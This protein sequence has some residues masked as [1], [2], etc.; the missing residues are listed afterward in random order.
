MSETDISKL[1]VQTQSSNPD[2][3]VDEHELDLHE[4]DSDHEYHEPNEENEVD[5][6][7]CNGDSECIT[8][9]IPVEPLPVKFMR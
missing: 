3:D 5:G 1:S 4:G 9:S 7:N 6:H 8:V 2:S